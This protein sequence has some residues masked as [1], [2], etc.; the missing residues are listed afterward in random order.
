[1]NERVVEKKASATPSQVTQSSSSLLHQRPLTEK[2]S[3]SVGSNSN[4][5]KE[6]GEIQPKTIRRRLNWQ[7]IPV[8]AP[9]RL[10]VSSTYS[11]GIQRFETS[12]MKE[13][14]ESTE[15]LQMQPEEAIQS[16]SSEGEPQGK[17]EQNKELV[18]AKLTVGAPGDRYEQEA[19]SMAAKVMR[20]PD[21][22]IQQPI[23][24]QIGEN[25][26]A[27]Q[28]QPLVNLITPV[29]QRSSEDHTTQGGG[30]IPNPPLR[31]PNRRHNINSVNQKT[32]AKEMNTMIEPG[33][34]VEDDVATINAG[35]ATREGNTFIVNGRTYGMH[36]GIL[37][38]ISG[39]GFHQLD[40][41]AFKALGVYNV[42]E[43]TPRA[44]EILNRMGISDAHRQTALNV[45]RI[46]QG[47][48]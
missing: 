9:S 24:H 29:L 21:Q 10:G 19:D 12:G 1:M 40:R 38:P 33:V 35:K 45:W 18:K 4:I 11:G 39:P 44:A 3:E 37:Y 23:Q 27:V 7:N 34:N 46:G 48:K 25:T 36:D 26:E 5:S 15:S 22:T 31:S 28:M 20:M 30:H 13:Q 8:E 6:S 47:G 32:V 17:E 14:E 43:D 41:G 16:K 2:L 42:F